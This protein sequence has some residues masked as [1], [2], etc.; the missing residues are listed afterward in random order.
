MLAEQKYVPEFDGGSL[1]IMAARFDAIA[2]R[3]AGTLMRTGRS[4]VLNRAKDLS[5]CIV[6]AEHELVCTADS[7]PIH[8]LAG[9]DLMSK[10]L[11]EFHG[12]MRPGD[13]FLNNSPYHGCSHAA[14]HTVLVPVFD[15]D[16]RHSFTLIVKAHQ[17]DIGNS[18]PTTYFARARDVYEEG[19]LVFPNVRVARDYVVEADFLRMCEQRIRAPKQWQGDFQAMLGAAWTGERDLK[20]LAETHGWPR[21]RAFVR[22]WLDY[23]ERMMVAAVSRLPQGCSEASTTHDPMPGTADDGVPIKVR[24]EIRPEVSQIVIDARDNP[25]QMAN[26]L[27]LSEACARTAALI[28]LF[29]SIPVNVPKNT[30]AFRPVTVLLRAGSCVGIPQHPASCSTAT[31]NLAD[32]LTAAGQLAISNIGVGLGMA[33][34]GPVNPP[35]KG[36]ISGLD[37]RTG[38]TFIDQLFLGSTG[39]AASADGDGWLTHSHSGNAGMSL[40]DSVELVE[41]CTPLIVRERMLVLDSEGAGE[42]I[43]APA[44]RTVLEIDADNIRIA[45]AS[46]GTYHPAKGA[47]GGSAGHPASAELIRRGV[48]SE[49][50]PNLGILELSRGDIVVSVGAGGGGYGLPDQRSRQSLEQAVRDGLLSI[51]RLNRVYRQN[52]S[53][54]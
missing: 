49:Q 25:D 9:P 40:V 3:M 27:N 23:S 31:T 48:E 17:A 53:T 22:E 52:L 51:E 16:R 11:C 32:R 39:G 30:G 7:L 12:D 6:S 36:V 2:R 29:N 54:S 14:D 24:V 43:G 1:A 13:A 5:C 46:D 18:Q 44:L 10:S 33:E 34:I 45:Y 20:A 28:G 38:K 21:L 19:A 26:G 42:F 8:V 41:L 47:C 35:S 50:L 4:G 37:R 15:S